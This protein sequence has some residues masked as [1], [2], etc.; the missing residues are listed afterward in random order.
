MVSPVWCHLPLVDSQECR[1]CHP[2]E[3]SQECHPWEDNQECHQWED[4]QECHQWE[5]SQECHPWEVN[6]ACPLWVCNQECRECQDS[7]QVW[8]SPDTLSSRWCSQECSSQE[9]VCRVLIHKCKEW[10]RQAWCK[11]WDRESQSWDIQ[12]QC[13]K[14]HEYQ[15]VLIHL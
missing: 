7:S 5:D 13:N 11:Q 12:V 10:C 2:W 9:E 6:Q 8:C 3:D 14:N 15:R 4:N 1:V